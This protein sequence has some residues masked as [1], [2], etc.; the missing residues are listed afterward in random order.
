MLKSLFISLFFIIAF[1][2]NAL[3]FNR[4]YE[5][6]D[7]EYNFEFS[8]M[9]I[10]K[11]TLKGRLSKD[12]KTYTITFDGKTSKLISIFYRLKEHIEGSVDVDTRRDLIYKSLEKT[13][14]KNK[15][16]KITFLNKHKAKVVII[17]NG[18]KKEVELISKKGIYSPISLY[19]FFISN[20]VKFGD[21]YYRDV[22]VASHVYRIE[23]TPKKLS[24]INI[25][26]MKNKHG[27]RETVEVEIRFFKIDKNGKMLP[28]KKMKKIV[29]WIAKD[30]PNIPL[31][32]ESWHLLGVFQARLTKLKYAKRQVYSKDSSKKINFP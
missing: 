27:K 7:A 3:S 30:N 21:S 13:S 26:R 28:D 17:K 23:I 32:I 2:L 25:D 6:F 10:A 29:A 20:K 31:L 1:S 15:S 5:D 22:A 24:Q 4:V 9:I 16:V 12:N 8:N 14:K 18:R 19:L 11:G